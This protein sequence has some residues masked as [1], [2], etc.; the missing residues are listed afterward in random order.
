MVGPRRKTNEIFLI[1]ETLSTTHMLQNNIVG[2]VATDYLD[3][4]HVA[5]MQNHQTHPHLQIQQQESRYLYNNT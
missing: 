2:N 4:L 3:V 5:H 1:M